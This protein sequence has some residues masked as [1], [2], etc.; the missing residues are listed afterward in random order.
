MLIPENYHPSWES[1]LT[2]EIRAELEQIEQ[3]I[4]DDFTPV[5]EKVLRFMTLDLNS[6]KVVILGQDPYKP[7]RV[8]NGRSFQP[9]NL[10]SWTQPFRQVSLKN[11]IRLLYR[12]VN[13]ITEYSKIPQYKA[14]SAEIASGAF[15][16][17]PP[18][19]W[20]DSLEAQGVL[21]LNTYLTCKIDVSN[22]HKSIWEGFSK[23]LLTYISEQNPQLNWFLWGSEALSNKPYIKSGKLY[24]SRHPMMCAENYPDDFLKCPCFAET[25]EIIN[26]LG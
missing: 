21:F 9:D 10:E 16:I 23:K 1:F 15:S 18:K 5:R 22:S 11:M 13:H 6:R 2:P 19:E 8:A 25:M 14:V 26:W 17:K 12:T 3:K 20:F 24:E 4:G 7:A